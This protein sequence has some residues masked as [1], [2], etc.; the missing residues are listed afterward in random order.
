MPWN[1]FAKKPSQN[2]TATATVTENATPLPQKAVLSGQ[3]ELELQKQSAKT[4]PY[5]A[6]IYKPEHILPTITYRIYGLD[7]AID[8]YGLFNF[9]INSRE[10]ITKFQTGARAYWDNYN[11]IYSEITDKKELEEKSILNIRSILNA[12]INGV[13]PTTRDAKIA[14]LQAFANKCSG[15]FDLFSL[16]IVLKEKIHFATSSNEFY[17]LLENGGFIMQIG[18]HRLP[19]ERKAEA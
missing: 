12:S 17:T 13:K 15:F 8:Q 7:G 5:W 6:G 1:P 3:E 19:I 9:K 4:H 10:E 2:P 18:D 14:N 16:P 11:N